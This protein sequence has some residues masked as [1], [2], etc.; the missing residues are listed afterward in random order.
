MREVVAYYD[1]HGTLSE[2]VEAHY[3]LGCV[4]RDMGEAPQALQCYQDAVALYGQTLPQD[5]GLLIRIY[6]QM[7]ELFMPRTSRA[8]I[9]PPCGRYSTMPSLGMTA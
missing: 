3:L 4:Y 2:R 5:V 1:R 6:G 9:S 7:A 8:T